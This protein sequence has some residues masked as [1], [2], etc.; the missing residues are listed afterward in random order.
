MWQPRGLPAGRQD[1][2]PRN[3]WQRQSPTQPGGEVQ[4]HSTYDTAGAHPSQEA[5]SRAIEHVVAPDPTF[6]GMRGPEPKTRDSV[7]MHTLLLVRT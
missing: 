6:I 7:W 1:P 4:R 3:T 2:E 5:R